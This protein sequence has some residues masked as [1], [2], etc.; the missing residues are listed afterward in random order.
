MAKKSCMGQN[1]IW[2][3]VDEE[4]VKHILSVIDIKKMIPIIEGVYCR[5]NINPEDNDTEEMRKYKDL[6]NKEYI[7]CLKIIDDVVNKV[8]KLY[9]KQISTGK[10]A[11]FCCDFKALEKAADTWNPLA[12]S[13]GVL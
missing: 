2:V 9:S 12:S 4:N 8:N 13:I 3:N 1:D 5:I 11:K 6:L 7:F 10:I